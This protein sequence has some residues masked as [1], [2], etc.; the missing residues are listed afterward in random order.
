MTTRSF[1]HNRT[2][3]SVAFFCVALAL[4]VAS[5][6]CVGNFS[7]K[8][9][10]GAFGGK[11]KNAVYIYMCGSTL[12]TNNAIA[13]KHI[14][15][16]LQT[17]VADNTAIIIETGGTRKWRGL[18]IP[19]D[20]IVRYQVKNGQLVELERVADSCM[21]DAQTLSSFISFCN[22]N[23]VAENT[24]LLFWNHGAGSVKGVCLD[25]NHDF[26]GLS[27]SEINEALDE[28]DSH[29]TNVCFDACLMANFETAR[30]LSNHARKM[31][32]SQEIEPAAGW[33][34]KTFIEN[35]GKDEFDEKILASYQAQCESKGKRLWTL[36]SVDLT[37]LAAVEAAFNSFCNEV[38]NEK[39]DENNLQLVTNAAINSMSFGEQNRMSNLIDLGQMSSLLGFDNLTQAIE[40]CTETVNG[41]DRKGATGLSIF[42]PLSGA[43]DLK[44]YLACETNEAYALF[45]GRNFISTSTTDTIKFLD[46]G[47]MS[48]NTFTFKVSPNSVNNIQGIIYDI[49]QLH[50]NKPATCLGFDNDIVSNDK[51]GFS[52]SFNGK[53]VALNGNILTCEPIDTVGDTTVFSSPVLLNGEDGDLRFT[54]NAKTDAF[55]F[56]GIVP[57]EVDRTQG[58]LQDV[59][60]GDEVTVLSEKFVSKGSLD[61]D[62]S[63][64]AIIT[65]DNDLE[66]S[67]ITLPDGKYQIYGIVT[68]LY[69]NESL[70]S[71]FVFKLEDGQ[72]T[73]SY[74]SG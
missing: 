2:F 51:G 66:L 37:K 11:Y 30:I 29:F 5:A 9:D 21:G 44:D 41:E 53:W 36:S 35:L 1:V 57:I 61:T 48:G 62:Y 6:F 72:I 27:A 63:E 20:A 33:D 14:S 67:T 15:D 47:S 65:V 28:T 32:A 46:E 39:A 60:K 7:H 31:I 12:E 4:L 69:G 43:T 49:Y 59:A 45:L 54:Y 18:D 26:D 73:E 42:F 55:S 56:Q 10:E 22:E 38:L 23:Y 71:N 16:I 52:I 68:D 8:V 19:N 74:V 58:R 24:T 13:T 17:K 64:T 70:T 40:N 34:Y 25:E 3:L 50:E